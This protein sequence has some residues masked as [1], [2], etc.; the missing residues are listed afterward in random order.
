METVKAERDVIESELK[1]ATI[2]MKDQF[3]HALAQDG[4]IN[5]PALSV[6]QIGKQL[7]PLQNQVQESVQH[8]QTLITD[9]QQ[10]H[11][12][13]SAETGNT[14]GG[15]R[16]NLFSE[17]AAAY[18]NFI[19]LQSNLIEGTKFYNDLTQLLVVF[20]NKISDFCFARKTEKDELLKDLTTESSRQTP[21]PT[22]TMPS[23]YAS[24]RPG[25]Y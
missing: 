13:F 1:S 24:T 6:A 19:E 4:A 17:L 23:H 12:E 14:G 3:L 7:G 16:E 2:N 8:Q 11:R 18:D 10:A 21:G 9:I 22:P 15:S 25:I 20:Q 5:E